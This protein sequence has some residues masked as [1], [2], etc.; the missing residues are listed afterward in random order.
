MDF[1][2]SMDLVGEY[3]LIIVAVVT[4]L[5]YLTLFDW[6]VTIESKRFPTIWKLDGQP[7]GLIGVFRQMATGAWQ[8]PNRLGQLAFIRL[9]FTWLFCNP[10]WVQNDVQ[11]YRILWSVRSLTI[12]NIIEISALLQSRIL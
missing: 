6:L 5:G 1:T 10:N 2:K 12:L 11:A 3:W 4:N 7:V 8:K 9:F